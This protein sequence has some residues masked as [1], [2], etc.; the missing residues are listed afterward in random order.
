MSN[1]NLNKL[2]KLINSEL[3]NKIYG[4]EIKFEELLFKRN[5][6]AVCSD[7]DNT[8]EILWL[9]T[10]SRSLVNALAIP[11]VPIIPQQKVLFKPILLI[12]LF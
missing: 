12:Y 9:R 5:W 3:S 4:S 10:Y 2:E 8:A 1:Q 7:R 6:L 11:P